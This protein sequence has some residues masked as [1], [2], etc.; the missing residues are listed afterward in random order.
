MGETPNKYN[1]RNKRKI[2]DEEDEFINEIVKPMR[3]KT[4]NQ[5]MRGSTGIEPNANISPSGDKRATDL[6]S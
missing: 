3:A 1:K 5:L 2:I 4:K 6:D